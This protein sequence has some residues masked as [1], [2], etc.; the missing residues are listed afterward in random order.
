MFTKYP[1]GSDYKISFPLNDV[2]NIEYK[3]HLPPVGMVHNILTDSLEKRPIL[4]KGNKKEDQKWTRTPLPNDWIKRR[5]EELRKKRFNPD[6]YDVELQ[7]FIDQEWDRRINGVWMMICGE[8]V[9]ITGE[10]YFYCN[11]M[12]TDFGYPDFWFVDLDFFYMWQYA[13]E[14]PNCYG[15]NLITGRRTGKSAKFGCV[16]LNYP[17]MRKNTHAGF[18]SK[19]Y[20]DAVRVFRKTIRLPFKNLPDFFQPIR[21]YDSKMTKNIEFEAQVPVGKRATEIEETEHGLDSLI[22]YKESGVFAYDGER[23]EIGG[24][25]ET[26]KTKECDVYER[27]RVFRPCL[28]KGDIIRGK[29]LSTTTVEV[30]DEFD[31]S[32]KFIELTNDSDPRKREEDGQTKSGLY[33]LFFPVYRTYMMDE[34]G[35]SLEAEAKNKISLRLKKF[36]NDEI[37][38]IKEKRKYPSSLDEALMTSVADCPFNIEILN[39]RDRALE[40]MDPRHLPYQVGDFEWI[41]GKEFKEVK[42]VPNPTNGKWHVSWMPQNTAQQNKVLVKQYGDQRY[43]PDNEHKLFAGVDPINYGGNSATAGKSSIGCVIRRGYDVNDNPD[44]SIFVADYIYRP[45]NPDDAYEH[46][47]KACWFYGCLIHIENNKFD[48]GNWLKNMGAKKFIMVRPENTLKIGVKKRPTEEGTAASVGVIDLYVKLLK[49]LVVNHGHEF[50][51]PRIIKQMMGFT[52]KNR[53][54]FDLVV[55]AGYAE[56]AHDA[57]YKPKKAELNWS[58]LLTHYE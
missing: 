58:P 4:F 21:N 49:K 36:E 54:K 9:Y 50:N 29:V 56:I 37:E 16:M 45:E 33:N 32:Y 20:A 18:Q 27:L 34:Y 19:T 40:N 47:F 7:E 46:I 48:I 5:K 53:T 44:K 13:R 1:N 8:P 11:W 55:A 22:D 38:L 6:H 39:K 43:V 25:D 3:V 2:E 51:H 35:R 26:G 23:I 24:F 52:V 57:P 17:S 30:D 14:D 12:K 28:E 15:I 10:H 41:T 42:F 31:V